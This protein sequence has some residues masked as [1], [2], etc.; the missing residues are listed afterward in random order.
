MTPS[1]ATSSTSATILTM[2]GGLPDAEPGTLP[3][4]FG[5]RLDRKVS[6][7]FD[8]LVT[9]KTMIQPGPDPAPIAPMTE[10]DAVKGLMDNLST[11]ADP[12]T[13]TIDANALMR[14]AQGDLGE[15]A[16]A[17]PEQM[18]Q[19]KKSAQYFLDHPDKFRALETADGRRLGDKTLATPDGQITAGDL[20]SEINELAHP[21][22][23]APMTEAKAVKTLSDNFKMLADPKT[24]LFD[25]N[26][27]MR[28]AQGKFRTP[29][30]TPEQ[31][32]EVQ[33]AAQYFLSHPAAF[34]TL[35]TAAGKRLHNK[36]MATAD[37]LV[38]A[39]DLAAQA[40][41]LAH[42]TPVASK[43]VPASTA[44]T[45]PTE[46]AAM[47]EAEA[48][49]ALLDNYNVLQS[50]G[51]HL[52]DMDGLMRA[53]HGDLRGAVSPDQADRM[54]KAAQ[55]FLDHP[56]E[57][58]ALETAQGR[59]KH[60]KRTA[61]PDGLISKGDLKLYLQD[62]EKKD[63]PPES[64]DT[65]AEAEAVNG[66][67]ENL[68]LI[69]NPRTGMIDSDD[70][71]RAAQGDFKGNATPEQKARA[72]K[73]AQYFLSHPQAF[74]ALETADGKRRHDTDGSKPDGEITAG[75]LASKANELANRAGTATPDNP[76]KP[77]IVL[78]PHSDWMAAN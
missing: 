31:G 25:T 69:A 40:N 24:G 68:T 45:K 39:S 11:L 46:P 16:T 44:P 65:K 2:P 62:L 48:T 12:E 63:A 1:A 37:G 66:L 43:P 30:G 17:T 36:R 50:P 29:P 53:A 49:K 23:A 71:M 60:N 27:L 58:K 73:A 18:A 42:P 32:Q 26:D 34:K 64:A 55:Y 54:K 22:K 70:L 5:A 9:E 19:V 35:E 67:M 41:V 59:H 75:D 72:K 38:S 28:A 10:A 56:K 13:G 20:A 6:D 51:K 15:G 57:F 78:Q 77:K 52:I 21:G 76:P 74:R 4:G 33:K 8:N 3:A 14:A 7:A 61:T 47:T